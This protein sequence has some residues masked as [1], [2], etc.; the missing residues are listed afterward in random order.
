MP[1]LTEMHKTFKK[2]AIKR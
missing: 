1:K 2:W